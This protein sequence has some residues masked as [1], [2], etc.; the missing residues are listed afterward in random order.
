MSGKMKPADIFGASLQSSH[1]NSLVLPLKDDPELVKSLV[2]GGRTADP[3][4]KLIKGNIECDT[5]HNPHVQST[6]K[7]SQ[8]FLVRDGSRTVSYVSPVTIPSA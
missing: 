6:D 2:G 7:V 3:A 1:P 4:V 8:N 5:C